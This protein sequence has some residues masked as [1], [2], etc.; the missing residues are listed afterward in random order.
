[1]HKLVIF[2]DPTHFVSAILVRALLEAASARDDFKIAAVCLREA[3]SDAQVARQR[4]RTIRQRRFQ[5]WFNH[6]LPTVVAAQTEPLDLQRLS[7]RHRFP[8]LVA[9][10][11]DFNHP[12]FL[13]Q[14]HTEVPGAIALSVYVTQV[15]S[16]AW[17]AN[18]SQAVNYHNGKLP[19]YRG[20]A[21]THWALYERQKYSGFAF[22]RITHEI[23]GGAILLQD[24]VAVEKNARVSEIEMRK[25]RLAAKRIPRL[26]DGLAAQEN[27]L[28][29]EGPGRLWTRRDFRTT[30]EV[31]DVSALDSHELLHRLRCFSLLKI[32][33]GDDFLP[34]TALE[35]CKKGAAPRNRLR[36]ADGKQF[37]ITRLHFLPPALYRAAT[38]INSSS[39]TPP[40]GLPAGLTRR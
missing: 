15:Y 16:P 29:H 35:E 10:D 38:A 18:F 28:A 7:K 8:L 19:D 37:R 17:V 22:H 31:P 21:A 33:V 39:M 9:P 5:K 2:T 4:R 34:V 11:S 26:L 25:A 6:D 23:D 40:S 1:V 30:T 36:T 3:I 20:L 27:G 14:I 24:Q 12:A 13:K 32:R